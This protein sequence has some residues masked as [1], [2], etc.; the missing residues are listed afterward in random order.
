MTPDEAQALR[1]VVCSFSFVVQQQASQL[2][3]Q[4]GG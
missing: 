1:A 2:G 3:D 4:S